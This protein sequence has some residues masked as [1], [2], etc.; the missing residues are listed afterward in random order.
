MGG[1]GGGSRDPHLPPSLLKAGPFRTGDVCFSTK[2]SSSE[3]QTRERVLQA[4]PHWRDRKP[5]KG[6][7]SWT[8]LVGDYREF[9]TQV[10]HFEK[11]NHAISTPKEESQ[12][13]GATLARERRGNRRNASIA[14]SSQKVAF[15]GYTL[16][17]KPSE[18][19]RLGRP[20]HF[21]GETGGA[22]QRIERHLSEK[23]V[24][25]NRSAP[26]KLVSNAR[27]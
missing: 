6:Q 2:S 19:G 1:R 17:H 14:S 5:K 25:L 21:D 7:E 16:T 12:G 4:T 13:R 20:R 24:K 23:N 15:I 3:P 27:S 22:A 11:P 18:R 10:I 26:R 9:N 8:G